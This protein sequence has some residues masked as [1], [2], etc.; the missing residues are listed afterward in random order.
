M[1]LTRFRKPQRWIA[2]DGLVVCANSCLAR[3]AKSGPS[4]PHVAVGTYATSRG[5]HI[6]Q[7]MEGHAYS[8]LATV[9][10]RLLLLPYFLGR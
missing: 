1:S 9:P 8:G 3:P 4:K 5:L 2:I 10:G 6:E 7:K